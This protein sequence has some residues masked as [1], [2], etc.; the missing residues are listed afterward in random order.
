MN[1]PN[2]ILGMMVLFAVL[3]I[4]GL[5]WFWARNR[6]TGTTER[7]LLQQKVDDL[8]QKMGEKNAQIEQQIAEKNIL[9]QQYESQQNECEVQLRQLLADKSLYQGQLDE[10]K[11]RNDELWNANQVL[12]HKQTQLLAQHETRVAEYE[13]RLQQLFAENGLYKGQLD[14]TKTRNAELL[15]ANQ[16][17]QAEQLQLTEKVGYLNEQ[18]QHIKTGAQEM[19]DQFKLIASEILQSQRQEMVLQAENSMKPLLQPLSEKVQ[20]FQTLLDSSRAEQNEFKGKLAQKLLD[21]GEIQK[22]L[23]QETAALTTALKG[24]NNKMIGAWGEVV[25]DRVL[26]LSG[27]RLG[28]E[29]VKQTQYSNQSGDNIRPDVVIA[30]PDNRAVIID[31]KVSLVHYSQYINDISDENLLKQHI[32]STR[33]HIKQLSEKRYETAQNL[34]TV[35]FVLMFMPIEAALSLIIEHDANLIE[36]ALQRNIVLTTPNTLIASLRLIE[37]LWRVDRQNRNVQEIV[38]EAS[39]L[40]DKFAYLAENLCEVK[41]AIDKAQDK[42]RVATRHVQQ[43]H[44]NIKRLQELGATPTQIM[45]NKLTQASTQLQEWQESVD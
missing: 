36:Y 21:L 23:Q 6:D 12:Q 32:N 13:M 37:Q 17:L 14:E 20:H 35:D 44:S 33:N 15:R 18:L 7:A 26:S 9:V 11:V 19:S 29:Y 43:S 28:Q 45:Q 24:G 1:N 31:A 25:L 41:N 16:S 30:L 34:N 40:Y 22:G 10:I 39:K 4:G 5:A 3:L 8:V 42:L 27:L 38:Q 2:F